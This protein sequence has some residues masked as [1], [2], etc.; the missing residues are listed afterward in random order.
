MI[1][2]RPKFDHRTYETMRALEAF[3]LYANE[4]ERLVSDAAHIEELLEGPKWQ[5]TTEEEEAEYRM[6]IDM[7]RHLHDRVVTP[8]FRYSMVVS[9]WAILER[10]MKRFAENIEKE[11]RSTVTYRD[12][13]PG[14]L[15]QMEKYL[16]VVRGF[17]IREFGCF[18]QIELLQI[19]RD[20]VVHCYGEPGLSRDKVALLR[21]NNPE[22]G[23]EAF[24]GLPIRIGRS[25]IDT[26]QTAVTELFRAMFHRVGWKTE[27]KG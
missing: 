17:S 14:L 23:F 3:R 8:T 19:V 20:C 5:P 6:E 11:S 13:R 10:E 26:S 1:I 16:I 22:A 7:A 27:T 12:F 4:I 25:F 15:Q 9:L 2:R 18:P 21:A 24:D